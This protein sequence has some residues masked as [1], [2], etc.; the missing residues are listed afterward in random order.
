MKNAYGL[1][2]H[3]FSDEVFDDATTER[4]GDDVNVTSEK[5]LFVGFL[6]LPRVAQVFHGRVNLN[7]FPDTEIRRLGSC[8]N[9]LKSSPKIQM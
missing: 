1:S 5:Q 2:N 3:L 6:R 8:K 4:I 9:K 7:F